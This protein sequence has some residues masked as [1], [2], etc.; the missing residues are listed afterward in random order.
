MELT[1]PGEGDDWLAL[2]T[3]PLSVGVAHD[4]AVRVDC[5]AVVVFSG[6]VRDHDGDRSGVTSLEYEAY[7]EQVVPRLEGIAAEVRA[8][9]PVVGRLVLIH[10][11]GELAVTE[12]SVIVAASAPHR[13][14]AFVAARFAIDTLKATVPIWKRETWAGGV[15]WVDRAEDAEQVTRP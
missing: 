15:D 1:V 14:E 9:W 10:R 11:I 5:G 13:A 12:P 4:W 3:E 7:E 6:V 2:T 8:R